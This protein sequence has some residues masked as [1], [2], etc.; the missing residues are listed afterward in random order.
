VQADN[1]KNPK[2]NRNLMTANGVDD[3]CSIP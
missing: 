2:I 1:P 3:A